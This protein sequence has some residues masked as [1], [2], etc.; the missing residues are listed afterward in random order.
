MK[1]FGRKLAKN[2]R[3]PLQ[4]HEHRK[5]K[6]QQEELPRQPPPGLASSSRQATIPA[7]PSSQSSSASPLTL[8]RALN[9]LQAQNGSKDSL[10]ADAEKRK[11]SDTYAPKMMLHGTSKS[12]ADSIEQEGLLISHGGKKGGASSIM[13]NQKYIENSKDVIHATPSKQTART[14]GNLHN[15]RSAGG[16]SG[17]EMSIEDNSAYVA[18]E[19]EDPKSINRDNDSDAGYKVSQSIP[20]HKVV[21][22]PNEIVEE[23]FDPTNPIPS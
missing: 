3:N 8:D 23:A 1:E 18:L 12:N 10:L 9:E 2:I 19:V 16:K 15:T 17:G 20:P 14:Y 11:Q 13:K 22:V 4:E 5:A 21:R 6:R 7:Q